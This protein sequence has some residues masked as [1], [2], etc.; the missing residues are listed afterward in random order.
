M[1]TLNDIVVLV[2]DAVAA[3]LWLEDDAERMSCR[4]MNKITIE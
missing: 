3:M 2:V 1:K 4:V